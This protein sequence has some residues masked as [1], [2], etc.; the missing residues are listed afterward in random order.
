MIDGVLLDQMML[1]DIAR[2]IG[3]VHIGVDKAE[4]RVIA[5]QCTKQ[6]F[7]MRFQEKIVL[8]QKADEFG[9][10]LRHPCIACCPLPPIVLVDNA[11]RIT[12]HQFIQCQPLLGTRTVVHDDDFLHRDGL[13]INALDRALY[14]A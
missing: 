1:D 4:S 9:R 13:C 2:T 3:L 6:G 7:A 11:K 10:R 12:Q 14:E 5:G 8:V